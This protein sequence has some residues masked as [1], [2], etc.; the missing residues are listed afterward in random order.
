MKAEQMRAK[1]ADELKDM[2]MELRKEQMTLR[3]QKSG[4]QLQNTAQLRNI[5]RDIARAKTLMNQQNAGSAKP[6]KAAKTDKAPAA[7]KA[8]KAPAAGTAAKASAKKS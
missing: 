7:K 5:R 3:F 8:A 4:Q 1:S 6:A 2:V